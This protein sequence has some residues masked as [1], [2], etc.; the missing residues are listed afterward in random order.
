MRFSP[1]VWRDI[2]RY[3]LNTWVKFQEFGDRLFYIERVTESEVTGIDQERNEFLL[4]LAE[5]EPYTLTYV[6]PHRAVFQYEG[7]AMLLQRIPA[8]QYKRGLS[9]ENTGIRLVTTTGNLDMRIEYLIA[10]VNKQ[11]YPSLKDAIFSSNKKRS[12]ALGGRFSF[13]KVSQSI[14]LDTR[15]I[16]RYFRDEKILRVLSLFRNEITEFVAADFF[17]TNYQYV[18]SL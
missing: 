3:Y 14:F 15:P 16:A 4:A 1:S 9:A 13:D 11:N 8:R 2:E 12:V 17:E 10:Y 7:N 6:L 5:E 18:E